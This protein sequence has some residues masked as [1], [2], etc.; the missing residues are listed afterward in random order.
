MSTAVTFL[1]KLYRTPGPDVVSQ[2]NEGLPVTVFSGL[3]D[4]LSLPQKF[5][6]ASLGLD[7]R[8]LRSRKK[9]QKLTPEESEK[10]FRVYRVYRRAQEVLGDDD[11]ARAWMTTPQR[12]LGNRAP[13]SL[14][15]RD[16]GTE[17]VLNILN[18]L[19]HNV[20]L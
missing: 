4:M 10:S 6:A 1:D 5:L 16:I 9:A 11:G 8:T 12:A 2:L 14:L 20:Y 15:V 17:E 19:E 7:D 18:A 13:I 3:S